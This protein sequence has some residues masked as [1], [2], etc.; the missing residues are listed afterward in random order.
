MKFVIVKH[1]SSNTLK[2]IEEDLGPDVCLICTHGVCMPLSIKASSVSMR[3]LFN[4]HTC[5]ISCANKK[6]KRKKKHRQPNLVGR[7]HP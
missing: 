4:E 3:K 5:R 1:L 7:L 6:E 2:Q